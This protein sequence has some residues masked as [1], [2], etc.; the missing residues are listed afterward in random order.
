MLIRTPRAS[1]INPSPT[2]APSNRDD[3]HRRRAERCGERTCY[4]QLHRTRRSPESGLGTA[5]RMDVVLY[6]VDALRF[7]AGLTD[8][9]IQDIGFEVALVGRQGFDTTSSINRYRFGY[10]S[11]ASA[12]WKPL[13]GCT[14]SGNGSTRMWIWGR[15]L[16]KSI[17]SH[18]KKSRIEPS[19]H[20]ES[21]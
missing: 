2:C 16:G 8:A 6:G 14:V 21:K 7:I 4:I 18:R 10:L 17:T 19:K 3:L 20:R 1:L 13:L 15:I 11:E 9:Q 5:I 12:V